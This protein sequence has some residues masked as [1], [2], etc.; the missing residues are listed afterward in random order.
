MDKGIDGLENKRLEAV[1]T[2][3]IVVAVATEIS[4][5]EV[6]KKQPANP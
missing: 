6:I 1:V 4:V 3:K 2:I 5:E